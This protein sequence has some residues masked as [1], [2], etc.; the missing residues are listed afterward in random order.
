[1][2][3]EP[4]L[5][6][7][8]TDVDVQQGLAEEAA[9]A[10]GRAG[11]RLEEALRAYRAAVAAGATDSEER[12]HIDRIARHL[13]ALLVQRECAGAIHGNLEQICAVYDI[14]AAALRRL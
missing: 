1:M 3:R 2:M 10:L 9:R 14:P 5:H 8:H 12:A 13:Y 11:A 4:T 7:G 6:P